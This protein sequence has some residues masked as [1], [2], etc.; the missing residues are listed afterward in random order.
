LGLAHAAFEHQAAQAGVSLQVSASGD[1]PPVEVDET[2]LAQVLA[3]LISNAL[4][5][6]PSGGQ[7]VLSAALDGDQVA[8]TVRDSGRGIPPEDLPFVFDRFYRADKSRSEDNGESGLGLAIV[9]ALVEAHGGKIEVQS[10]AGQGTAF[11]LRLPAAS[12][13]SNPPKP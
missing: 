9:K 10:A 7:I 2:R 1:L 13:R 3:N 11:T 4:R 5:F 8:L 6:T 12:P